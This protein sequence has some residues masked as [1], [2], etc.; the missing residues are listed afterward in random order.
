MFVSCAAYNILKKRHIRVFGM[1]LKSDVLAKCLRRQAEHRI[2]SASQSAGR[3]TMTEQQGLMELTDSI[4]ATSGRA[5]GRAYIS[6][7]H[8]SPLN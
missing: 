2:P 3:L 6:W 4:Y 1:T 8:C 5:L 7:P